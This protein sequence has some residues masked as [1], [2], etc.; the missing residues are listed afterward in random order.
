MKGIMMKFFEKIEVK[1]LIYGAARGMVSK[2]DDYS[3]F[4]K[5]TILPRAREDF[6]LPEEYYRFSLK[7]YGIDM[8]LNKNSGPT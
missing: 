7:S 6:R 3:Q 5:N 8:P 2:L 1:D 4:I